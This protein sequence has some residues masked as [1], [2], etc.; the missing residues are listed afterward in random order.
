[1]LISEFIYLIFFAL[2]FGIRSIGFYEGETA[3]DI[4]IVAGMLLFCYKLAV[5]AHS[6]L[7]WLI[8]VSLIAIGL[9]VY[10]RTGEKGL[11]FDF[12][13][14]IGMKGVNP[15][16][17][18]RLA[19]IILTPS[20]IILAMLS[21]LG[22]ISDRHFVHERWPVGN[23]FRRSLGYPYPNSA[24]TTFVVFCLIILYLV[25]LHS[26]VRRSLQ[27][28]FIL[29]LFCLYYYLYTGTYTGLMAFLV[30]IFLNLVLQYYGH[31]NKK[32]TMPGVLFINMFYPLT[33][34]LCV[35]VPYLTTIERK[36]STSVLQSFVERWYLARYY[37]E[38]N[39]ITWF[40]CR[41]S[42]PEGETYGLDM[43]SMYLF[44]NLGIVAFA[45]VSITFMMMVWDMTKRGEYGRIAMAITYF[46]LGV[47]DPCLYNLSFKNLLFVFA[48]EYLFMRTGR[49]RGEPQF[50]LL[51]GGER[52]IEMRWLNH[53][54]QK[55]V[56]L[57]DNVRSH[58]RSHRIILSTSLIVFFTVLLLGCINTSKINLLYADVGHEDNAAV[59]LTKED[60][61]ELRNQNNL[62][63]W[64]KSETEPMYIYADNWSISHPANADVE[65]SIV[66][67]EALRGAIS[68]ALWSFL[69]VYLVLNLIVLIRQRMKKPNI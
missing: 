5:T 28:S 23:I 32:I 26:S 57:L 44:L 65:L 19:Q 22:I 52:Q 45:V 21:S 56:K 51:P 7:E 34:F 55:A 29:L 38:N 49:R 27:I 64:Y 31:H 6:K 30:Y 53:I 9:C 15:E 47:T 61:R 25:G 16:R 66:R 63:L 40:G 68:L 8:I 14:M 42:N 35:V 12:A 37:I 13:M 1:M 67:V 46:L 54:C 60:V 62:V 39:P 58:R 43:S 59:Y 11:L 3:Y 4:A 24:M 48:G 33:C 69:A 36:D 18:F 20:I 17:V 2:M 41:L 10:I 50:A